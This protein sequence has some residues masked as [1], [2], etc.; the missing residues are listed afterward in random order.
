MV[1]HYFLINS[2]KALCHHDATAKQHTLSCIG[3]DPRKIP[4]VLPPDYTQRIK[5]GHRNKLEANP[6]SHLIQTKAL[7]GIC[8][9]YPN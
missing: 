4:G 1:N 8:C 6:E 5:L 3:L 9:S 2:T 7:H